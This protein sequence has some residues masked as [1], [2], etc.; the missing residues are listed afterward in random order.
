M[1]YELKYLKSLLNL[2]LFLGPLSD[3]I[4]NTFREPESRNQIESKLKVKSTVL[5]HFLLSALF[6]TIP[7]F[8]QFE[9]HPKR[10]PDTENTP[11]VLR[12]KDKECGCERKSEKDNK[13]RKK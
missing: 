6:F 3:L 1:F 13:M 4:L 5:M 7:S 11:R 12:E 9:K 8:L 10:I 2:K